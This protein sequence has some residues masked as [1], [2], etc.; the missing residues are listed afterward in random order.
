MTHVPNPDKFRILIGEIANGLRSALNY[1]IGRLSELDC[2]AKGRNTQFPIETSPNGFKGHTA[3]YLEGLSDAHVAAIERLQPYNGCEWATH[4]Q[5]LS[6]LH[7]HDDLIF[8]GHVYNLHYKITPTEGNASELSMSMELEPTLSIALGD[9]LPIIETLE[10]IK[11]QVAQTLD[12][13][14][15]EF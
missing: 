8:V 11:S 5:R 6:N 2:G 7:K 1:L 9:G 4:L 15:P 10:V 3:S 12:A 14:K 13:F